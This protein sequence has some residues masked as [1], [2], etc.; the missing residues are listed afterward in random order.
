MFSPRTCSTVFNTWLLKNVESNEQNTALAV[1]CST[2]PW[3]RNAQVLGWIGCP[4][5]GLVGHLVV[6]IYEEHQLLSTHQ[7]IFWCE[8]ISLGH[9]KSDEGPKMPQLTSWKTFQHHDIDSIPLYTCNIPFLCF[10]LLQ[11]IFET[12]A[13]KDSLAS[14]IHN[15]GSVWRLKAVNNHGLK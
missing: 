2:V 8:A 10:V 5:Q 15:I 9:S 12:R 3:P 11:R 14:P 6:L 7:E 13:S 4:N 1:R